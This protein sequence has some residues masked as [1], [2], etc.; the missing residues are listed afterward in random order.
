MTAHAMAPTDE[1]FSLDS[2][3]ALVTTSYPTVFLTQ[4]FPYRSS[5]PHVW[6]LSKP[7][8]TYQEAMARPDYDAWRKA[9]DTEKNAMDDLGVFDSAPVIVLPKGKRAIGLR[10]V[11]IWKDVD[12][13]K[14]PK[15]RI[16]AQ[17]HLQWPDDYGNTYAPVAKMTSICVIL[18]YTAREDL[19]LYTFDVCTA[20]LNAPLHEE[21]YAKQIPGYPLENPK[22]SQH[23]LKAIYGLKQSPHEW[24][25]EFSSVLIALGLSS[26]PVDEAVFTGRWSKSNPHPTLPMPKDGSNIF[27]IIPIRVDDGLAATN[28]KDLYAWLIDSLNRRFSIKNLGAASMFLGIR[29]ERDRAVRKLWLSQKHFVMDLLATHNMLQCTK[30][31]VPLHSKLDKLMPVPENALPNV[32]NAD[33]QLLFQ[34]LTGSY[35]Y[36]AVTTRPD[37]TFTAMALGQFNSCPNRALLSAAKG[38]LRYLNATSDWSLEY[39]GAYLQEKVGPDA[40]V[41]SDLALVDA[42]WASD[43]RDRKSISGYGVF[44]YGDLVSWSSMKQKSVSLSSTESEYMA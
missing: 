19:E 40:V 22:S 13:T 27:I 35:I 8:V 37:L 21:V 30:S 44:L 12:D 41:R 17:G 36:L 39:G 9:M 29:I 38:V 10:W 7:P 3:D 15:A 5:A 42:D 14:I 33:I 1:Y 43:E 2:L 4:S 6:D 23:L 16:V 24:F 31:S 11:F 20:F 25:R 26:C 34:S 32:A 18:A 28:S